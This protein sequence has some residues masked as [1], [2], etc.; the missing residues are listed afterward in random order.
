MS[1]AHGADRDEVVGQGLVQVVLRGRTLGAA[2]RLSLALL[3]SLALLCTPT[4][5]SEVIS[6]LHEQ[7]TCASMRQQ[8]DRRVAQP[9]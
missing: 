1:A 8:D 9:D 2:T 4:L 3:V 5:D 6:A 7:V